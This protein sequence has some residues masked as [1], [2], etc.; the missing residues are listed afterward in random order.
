M[1]DRGGLKLTL[2]TSMLLTHRCFEVMGGNADNYSKHTSS[3]LVAEQLNYF[4]NYSVS[5]A[6][7]LAGV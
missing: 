5:S 7:G 3:N 6:R 1:A 2:E 4:R